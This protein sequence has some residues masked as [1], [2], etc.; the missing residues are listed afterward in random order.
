[1]ILIFFHY[2]QES[3][4]DLSR[5]PKLFRQRV[6][7]E[8][9]ELSDHN[10]LA[11]HVGKGDDDYVPRVQHFVSLYDSFLRNMGSSYELE[12]P[13]DLD[14]IITSI[15]LVGVAPVDPQPYTSSAVSEMMRDYSLIFP[16]WGLLAGLSFVGPLLVAGHPEYAALTSLISTTV[17]FVAYRI[18]RR[19]VATKA[20][21]YELEPAARKT[22][23]YLRTLH[24][25]AQTVDEY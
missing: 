5:L 17:P 16:G 18:G 6:A 3:C 11:F 7:S 4:Q 24:Q 9:H 13:L 1:M 21:H 23:I 15:N 14:L 12:F 25:I 10:P 2:L 20:L 8:F 22:T 19:P